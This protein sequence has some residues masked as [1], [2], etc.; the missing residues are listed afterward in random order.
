MWP[1]IFLGEAIVYW[2]L[3]QRNSFRA[4]SWAHCVIF[5][6]AFL[7]NILFALILTSQYRRVSVA[8]IRVNRRIMMHEQQ[9]FF[10]GL[11]ILAHLAFVAVLANC[12][13][14]AAP[15]TE[16]GGQE[17]LLDDVVL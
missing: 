2:L 6:L 7:L 13:R 17:N 11:V 16:N 8:E 15:V 12:F 3:R 14:K 5:I 4:L 1:A 9:Y 10:W